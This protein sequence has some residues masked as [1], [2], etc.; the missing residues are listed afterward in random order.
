MQHLILILFGHGFALK[1]CAFFGFLRFFLFLNFTK[2]I[3]KTR[4]SLMHDRIAEAHQKAQLAG[5]W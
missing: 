2:V 3:V 4:I 1:E 5:F